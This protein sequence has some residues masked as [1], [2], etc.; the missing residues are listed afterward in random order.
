MVTVTFVP[1]HASMA[2]GIVKARGEPHSKVRFVPQVRTGA[3][4]STTVI[5][6]LQV[7]AFVQRSVAR[8][9]RMTVNRI[10]QMLVGTLVT[11]LRIVTVTFVPSQVSTAAGGVN[12]SGAPHSRVKLVPQVRTGGVVSTI[13]SV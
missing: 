4:V 11:V 1:S 9:V 3:V 12:T 2:L 8:Q 5:V 7:L 13:V 6:W 10:G